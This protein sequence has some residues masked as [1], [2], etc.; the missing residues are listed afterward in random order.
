MNVFENQ[1]ILHSLHAKHLSVNVVE[2]LFRKWLEETVSVFDMFFTLS[3][4]PSLFLYLY[5]LIPLYTQT[6]NTTCLVLFQVDTRI[7]IRNVYN[8]Q[9]RD[10]SRFILLNHRKCFRRRLYDSQYKKRNIHT[11]TYLCWK[12]SQCL[13]VK[14]HQKTRFQF[15]NLYTLYIYCFAS[16]TV[17]GFI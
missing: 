10:K 6:S 5:T 14:T 1:E 13:A 11:L 17:C 16:G 3:F 4:S 9:K 12:S 2:T 8:T 15:K 7:R